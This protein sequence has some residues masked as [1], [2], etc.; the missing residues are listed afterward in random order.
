[1]SNA[2]TNQET[3]AQGS[4]ISLAASITAKFKCCVS[5]DTHETHEHNHAHNTGIQPTPQEEDS[6]DVEITMLEA[7][8][9]PEK[10][11]KDRGL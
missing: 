3:Q 5:M 10:N 2:H 6:E 7:V 8:E 4:Y 11:A 9:L 1:M